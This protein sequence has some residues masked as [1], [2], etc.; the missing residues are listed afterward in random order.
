MNFGTL[1]PSYQTSNSQKGNQ[2]WSKKVK[3]QKISCPLWHSMSRPAVPNPKRFIRKMALDTKP[4]FSTV[5]LQTLISFKRGKCLKNMLVRAKFDRG[6]R[7]QIQ[8]E[9]LNPLRSCV[10]LSILA[11][12]YRVDLLFGNWI[13]FQDLERRRLLFQFHGGT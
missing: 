5:N 3:G 2:R 6:Q 10:G 8:L 1:R 4:T 9:S 13:S 11:S 7:P 12:S